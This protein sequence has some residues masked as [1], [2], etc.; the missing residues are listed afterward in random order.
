MTISN[1]PQ[2]LC[3]SDNPQHVTNAHL[4]NP[5]ATGVP[6]ETEAPEA[7]RLTDEERFSFLR[8]ER[9][10]L[11]QQ[12]QEEREKNA[13]LARKHQELEA[14]IDVTRLPME[15]KERRFQENPASL[16][17]PKKTKPQP[18]PDPTTPKTKYVS[19]EELKAMTSEERLSLDP[20]RF[21]RFRAY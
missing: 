3:Y 19:E 13:T 7:P 21:K 10:E 18:D 17:L 6:T 14:S 4:M 15:E 16:G 20:R 8:A 1:V 9:R 2:V 12:L 11:E 5:E